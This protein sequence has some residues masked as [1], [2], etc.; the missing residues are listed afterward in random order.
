MDDHGHLLTFVGELGQPHTLGREAV[1]KVKQIK[2]R[3][4]RLAKSWRENL[5]VSRG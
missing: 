4:L 3:A 1:V 2:C 5:R